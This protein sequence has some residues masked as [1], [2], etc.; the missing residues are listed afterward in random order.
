MSPF[1][2]FLLL[3]LLGELPSHS[4]HF[5]SPPTHNTCMYTPAACTPQLHVHPSCTLYRVAV[6]TA[7]LSVQCSCMHSPALCRAQQL[8]E[9]GGVGVGVCL[10]QQ[11]QQKA[12]HA[13]SST[14]E[15]QGDSKTNPRVVAP[16]TETVERQI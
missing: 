14:K 10:L 7:Q 11:Q 9:Q 12:A 15:R 8:S 16:R 13:I 1:V 6:C 3:P 2:S 5:L 4:A